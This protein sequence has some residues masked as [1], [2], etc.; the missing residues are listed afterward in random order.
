ML[1]SGHKSPR[2]QVP[3]TRSDRTN[4]TPPSPVLNSQIPLAAPGWLMNLLPFVCVWWLSAPL[5]LEQP[6]FSYEVKLSFF[7]RTPV[8]FEALTS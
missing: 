5:L 1:Q 4:L 6:A 7:H 2:S 8:A 3:E